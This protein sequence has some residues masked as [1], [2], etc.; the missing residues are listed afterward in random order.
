MKRKVLFFVLFVC[1]VLS[2]F[3]QSGKKTNKL[4]PQT[5]DDI[6]KKLNSGQLIS[7]YNGNVNKEYY[8]I[9]KEGLKMAMDN[10]DDPGL[11]T[12]IRKIPVSYLKIFVNSAIDTG[13]KSSKYE[14]ERYYS[15]ARNAAKLISKVYPDSVDYSASIEREIQN[16][17]TQQENIKLAQ[18]QQRIEQE[19]QRI[20]QE[21]QRIFQEERYHNPLREESRRFIIITSEIAGLTLLNGENSLDITENNP[22]K[23]EVINALERNSVDSYR[24]AVRDN[25]GRIFPAD[26]YVTFEKK[27]GGTKTINIDKKNKLIT[28]DDFDFIQN[29]QGG[30]TIRRYK[31]KALR[32][33]IP[34][35]ISG[36]R[37][38]EIADDAFALTSNWGGLGVYSTDPMVVSLTSVV[39]PNTVTRIGKGAFKNNAALHSVVLPNAITYIGAGAFKD[40][41]SLKSITIPRSITEISDAE[42]RY[43]GVFENCGLT[44]ISLHNNLIKIG[45]SAFSGN[46][47]QEVVLPSSLKRVGA[48]AFF[49]NKINKL[50]IP[51]GVIFLGRG[52]FADNPLT[53]VTIPPSL[54]VYH[55]SVRDP[56]ENKGFQGAFNQY[57]S[58]SLY[59]TN[60]SLTSITLPANVDEDNLVIK[61]S[62]GEIMT[63]CVVSGESFFNFWKSQ[64]GKAGTYSTDERIWT[65]K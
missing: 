11:V 54:A 8:A 18:E 43:G 36:I 17:I 10:I 5:I 24:I 57:V 50:V 26:E 48:F 62:Y 4:D 39:I 58:H 15:D 55:Y 38:T 44:T 47:L 6:V 56:T 9:F 3:G 40:C 21:L 52:S 28:A 65:V 29:Q 33:E 61:N 25:E 59:Y 45:S 64:N 27:I 23:I 12:A 2:V 13:S 1:L 46:Q 51:N 35:T 22:L 20:E 14:V 60:S 34:Q 42:E 32:I 31:G 41:K 16:K 37:V 7:G 53:N 30:I 19:Q 63:Y 49:N